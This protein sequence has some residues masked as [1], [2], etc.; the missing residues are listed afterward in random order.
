MVCWLIPGHESGASSNLAL[1]IVL[2]FH[3]SKRQHSNDTDPKIPATVPFIARLCE[4]NKRRTNIYVF[5]VDLSRRLLLA[6]DV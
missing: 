5:Q 3:L 1:V 2:L 6:F 4:L